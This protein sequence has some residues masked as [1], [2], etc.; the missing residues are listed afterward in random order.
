[1]QLGLLVPVVVAVVV[2]R[3]AAVAAAAAASA[4]AITFALPAIGRM[5]PLLPGYKVATAAAATKVKTAT[6]TTKIIVTTAAT[7]RARAMQQWQQ[8][9]LSNEKTLFTS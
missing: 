5:R 7:T 1:M 9:P 2:C 8:L 6:L 3:V 4:V